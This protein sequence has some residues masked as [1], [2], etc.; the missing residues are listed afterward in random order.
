MDSEQFK[1]KLKQ[2]AEWYQCESDNIRSQRAS[3]N[4]TARIQIRELKPLQPCPDCDL[5]LDQPRR[6]SIER[7]RTGAWIKCCVNC[8]NCLNQ[9]TGRYELGRS[10]ARAQAQGAT[11]VRTKSYKPKNPRGRPRLKSLPSW[12]E[13]SPGHELQA[14]QPN[15]HECHSK[16][17]PHAQDDPLY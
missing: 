8:R 3:T 14:V 2:Y 10:A 6:Q 11:Q 12:P 17:S 7:T 13:A 15:C 16:D 4:P 1:Q 5:E 9:K